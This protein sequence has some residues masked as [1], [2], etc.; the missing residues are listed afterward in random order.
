VSD[1]P[2]TIE[3]QSEGDEAIRD[4][5]QLTEQLDKTNDAS[6]KSVGITNLLVFARK[7]L[8]AVSTAIAAIGLGK[9]LL[10]EARAIDSLSQ[11]VESSSS[12]IQ[13]WTIA[14]KKAG[15]SIDS[16][17]DS[18]L[19]LAREQGS[20]SSVFRQMGLDLNAVR[21]A[22][23]AELFALVAQKISD[24]NMNAT[25]MSATIQALGSNG[26]EVFAALSNGFTQFAEQARNDGRIIADDALEPMNESVSRLENSFDRLVDTVKGSFTPALEIAAKATTP[27]LDALSQTVIGVKGLMKI[28]LEAGKLGLGMTV[29]GVDTGKL[30]GGLVKSVEDFGPNALVDTIEQEDTL[31][32]TRTN[33]GGTSAAD[34]ARRLGQ[35]NR[36]DE[37]ANQIGGRQAVDGFARAG[38]YVTPGATVGQTAQQKNL[39]I[40]RRI[41]ENTRDTAQAVHKNG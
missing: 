11:S 19:N 31:N 27:V 5:K 28:G 41:A 38:L 37:L 25:Q 1:V 7:R 39:A 2:V 21:S 29:P 35:A 40:L 24:G 33:R 15:T 8:L 34:I 12:Q 32:A 3:F 20:D 14:A 18:I 10:D 4:A 17:R 36:L 22:Q 26:E 13:V 23:P 30:A 6:D 9:K 16:I